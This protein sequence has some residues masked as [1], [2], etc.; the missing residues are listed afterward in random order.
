MRWPVSRS[1]VK[2]PY[3]NPPTASSAARRRIMFVPHSMGESKPSWPSMPAFRAKGVSGRERGRDGDGRKPPE[4]PFS[5]RRRARLAHRDGGDASGRQ[6]SRA[7]LARC[8]DSDSKQSSEVFC[9]LGRPAHLVKR[10]ILV[11]ERVAHFPDAVRRREVLRRL[12]PPEV[13][14]RVPGGGEGRGR[15]GG[16]GLEGGREAVSGGNALRKTKRRTSGDCLLSPSSRCCWAAAAAV[17]SPGA[18]GGLWKKK[19][20]V[21]LRKRGCGR[22]S[23][24]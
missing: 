6:K 21:A 23:L 24:S 4:V 20:T 2:V 19:G 22:M 1:S 15:R 9:S 17:S 10:R 13:V 14:G 3:W 5:W 12:D 16:R 7:R 11:A 8:D 18:A